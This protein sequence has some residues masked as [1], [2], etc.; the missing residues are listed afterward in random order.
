MNER[1]KVVSVIGNKAVEEGSLRFELAYNIGKALVD[2]GYRVQSGGLE[3]I[4]RAV[5]M[6]AKNIKR[7][8]PLRSYPRS[9]RKSPTNS[10]IFPCP[11]GST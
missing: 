6:G 8:I 7:A 9:I 1:R 2:N 4:M 11:R 10:R 5:M 3:G